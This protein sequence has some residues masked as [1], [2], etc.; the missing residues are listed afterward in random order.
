MPAWILSALRLLA[1]GLAAGGAFEVG[2]QALSGPIDPRTGSPGLF[3]GIPFG[4]GFKKPRKRRRRA[5]T[6]SDRDD[7]AFLAAVVGEPTARKFALI[8]AAHRAT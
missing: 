5:L 7:I 4:I 3:G 6:H 2:Q 8:L 1:G